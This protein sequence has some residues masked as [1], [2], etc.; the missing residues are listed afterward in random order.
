MFEPLN[1]TPTAARI[2]PNGTWLWSSASGESFD[3]LSGAV[4]LIAFGPDDASLFLGMVRE[5][6]RFLR[7]SMTTMEVRARAVGLVSGVRR[8]GVLSA[9]A[10][11]QPTQRQMLD[12]ACFAA[13]GA[14]ARI[15]RLF[16]AYLRGEPRGYLPRRTQGDVALACGI[17]LRSVTRAFTRL[18]QRGVLKVDGRGWWFSVPIDA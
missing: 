2:F 15:E 17:N 4:E 1:P 9:Q 3:L 14:D 5:P 8:A 16:T 10:A 13:L 12:L 18:V 7:E 11:W 6:V